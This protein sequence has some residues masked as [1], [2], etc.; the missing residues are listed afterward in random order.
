MAENLWI[1]AVLPEYLRMNTE[2][3]NNADLTAAYFGDIKSTP[4]KSRI[5][6]R[7]GCGKTI[8]KPRSGFTPF[9]SHIES[10]HADTYKDVYADYKKRRPIVEGVMDAFTASRYASPS[11]RKVQIISVFKILNIIIFVC[12]CSVGLSG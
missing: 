3:V 9:V 12:R 10:Q 4:D 7:G 8:T 2:S 1:F 11:A 6:C 5:A